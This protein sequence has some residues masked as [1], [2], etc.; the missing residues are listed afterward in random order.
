MENS[1]G[2]RSNERMRASIL[3]VVAL[4]VL[5]VF[6]WVAW[7]SAHVV[8]ESAETP[9]SHV[10]P[11][12]ETFVYS[13]ATSDNIKVDTPSPGAVVGH[14]VV[15]SG[16]ARGTWYFEASFPASIEDAVG[17]VIDQAPAQAQADW[18]TEELVPFSVTLQIPPNYSGPAKIILRNDNPSG[19][20]A[21]DA[22]VSYS[23]TV[24]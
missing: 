23:V 21:R 19:D 22:S 8:P 4:L 16:Q 9:G 17:H 1:P 3:I 24:Q 5:G 7:Y 20:P 14:A 11:N 13:N 15:I 2:A 6:G 18:M 12:D 10:T